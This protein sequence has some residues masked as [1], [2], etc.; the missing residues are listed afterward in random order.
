METLLFNVHPSKLPTSNRKFWENV[1]YKTVFDII[2]YNCLIDGLFIT[3]DR[4]RIISIA[5][6]IINYINKNKILLELI[7][8]N[9][10]EMT[11]EESVHNIEVID[12]V[13]NKLIKNLT[14]LKSIEDADNI[15]SSNYI[16]E[17]IKNINKIVDIMM[18]VDS[19]SENL[20]ELYSDMFLLQRTEKDLEDLQYELYLTEEDKKKIEKLKKNISE[21][22][23]LIHKKD[24][25]EILRENTDLDELEKSLA[26][27][28]KNIE[29]L[30]KSSDNYNLYSIVSKYNQI[31]GENS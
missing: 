23:E 30:E 31:C 26:I 4:G 15:T 3:C 6:N 22:E 18:N 29:S 12:Y 25:N 8:K 13:I 24:I 21:I 11:Y 9:M 19:E 10:Y 27:I 28:K 14:L 17:I 16:S 1:V 7:I 2:G 5:D 20:K